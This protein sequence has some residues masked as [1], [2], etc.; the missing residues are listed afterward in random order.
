MSEISQN[1]LNERQISE[2]VHKKLAE[3]EKQIA[4]GVSPLDAEDSL[5]KIRVKYGLTDKK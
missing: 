4:D 1:G 2:E 3:A 5:N